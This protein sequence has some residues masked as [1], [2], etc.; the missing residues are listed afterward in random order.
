MAQADENVNVADTKE[1]NELVKQRSNIRGRLTVF[2]KY[3]F[4]LKIFKH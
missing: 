3:L 4:T 1:F 2:E